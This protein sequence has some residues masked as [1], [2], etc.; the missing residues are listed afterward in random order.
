MVQK[1]YNVLC[2]PSG[3]L[4]DTSSPPPSPGRELLSSTNVPET[5]TAR[6]VEMTS[7]QT[8]ADHSP[9][10]TRSGDMSTL[11]TRLVPRVLALLVRVMQRDERHAACVQQV[12]ARLLSNDTDNSTALHTLLQPAEL[13]AFLDA[14]AQ[15][16]STLGAAN[17]TSAEGPL[18]MLDHLGFPI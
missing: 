11:R 15:S 4:V 5:A 12:G 18:D 8:G 10:R 17:G 7:G 14:I 13:C 3:W 1:L 6:C 9:Q 16:A 2:F